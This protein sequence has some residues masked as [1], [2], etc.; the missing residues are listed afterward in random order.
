MPPPT[1]TSNL[2]IE[3]GTRILKPLASVALDR[4]GRGKPDLAGLSGKML[5]HP[6]WLSMLAESGMYLNSRRDGFRRR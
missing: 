6:I 4:I 3:S 5:N 1:C 2:P